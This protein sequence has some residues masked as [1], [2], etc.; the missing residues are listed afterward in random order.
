MPFHQL[1]QRQKDLIRECIV[2][3]TQGPFLEEWEFQMRMGIT[4][5]ELNT[6]LAQ[7]PDFDDS[8]DEAVETLA[9][10][11]CM[12]EILN[13]V[14]VSPHQS[15]QWFTGTELEMNEAYKH[16]AELRGSTATGIM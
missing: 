8:A 14:F 12:N 4:R 10:N 11:N 7:W 9:I 15:E 1:P 6:V 5:A 3:I 13:G 16:W 2:A